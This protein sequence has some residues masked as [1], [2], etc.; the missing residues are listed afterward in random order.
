MV[1]WDVSTGKVS[2]EEVTIEVNKNT[3]VYWVPRSISE[4]EVIK[5]YVVNVIPLDET[6]KAIDKKQVT[7]NYDGAFY[8]VKPS[9]DIIIGN[10]PEVIK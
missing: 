4:Q 2:E 8:T 1:T 7:I 5:S 10:Q 3:P 9:G 6:G